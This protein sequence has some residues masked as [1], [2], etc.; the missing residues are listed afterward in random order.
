MTDKETMSL[1]VKVGSLVR[2]NI[3]DH[4]EGRKPG[5][6]FGIVVEHYSNAWR[7]RVYWAIGNVSTNVWNVWEKELSVLA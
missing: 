4:L 6:N 3:Y 7:C 1:R 5:R 2:S